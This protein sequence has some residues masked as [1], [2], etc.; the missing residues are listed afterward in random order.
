VA[1]TGRGP[2]IH[3][4]LRGI[5][6]LPPPAEIHILGPEERVEFPREAP[7]LGTGAS[8]AVHG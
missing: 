2:V 6:I 4:V 7:V 1:P 8:T 3:L 5:V